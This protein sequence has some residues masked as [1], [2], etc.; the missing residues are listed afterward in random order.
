MNND[1]GRE[2]HDLYHKSECGVNKP[3]LLKMQSMLLTKQRAALQKE[4]ES[5]Q[6]L[7]DKLFYEGSEWLETNGLGG[8]AGSSILGCNTRRYHGL[9]VAA[10]KP[11]TERMVL[12]S[13]LDETVVVNRKRFELGTNVYGDN[14]IHPA[15]HQYLVSFSKELF[16]EWLYDVD[17][18]LIKKRSEERRVGKECRSRWSP[19]H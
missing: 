4:I 15:G 6:V 11:P 1:P 5:L 16:P 14:V 19:Y 2:R 17:G 7:T 8:W 9:L 18:I 12:L 10:T 3:N 13:K